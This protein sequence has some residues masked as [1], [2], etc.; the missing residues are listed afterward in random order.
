M[1]RKLLAVLL[2]GGSAGGIEGLR[3][4]KQVE[5]ITMVQ[6]PTSSVDPRLAEAAL[7]E[8]IV[9]YKSSADTLAETFRKLIG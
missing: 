9:D 4:V 3:A 2:S 1:G 6:D 5:G 8:G 7:Q